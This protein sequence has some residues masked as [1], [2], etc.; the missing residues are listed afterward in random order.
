MVSCPKLHKNS[1][2]YAIISLASGMMNSVFFFYYVN[3]FLNR[4][5]IQESWFQTSQVLFMIWNAIND[6]LFGYWQDNFRGECFKT[7]SSAIKYGALLWAISFLLPWFPWTNDPAN[8][9]IIGIHL[10]VS[11]FMYDA[12][13]T[14][15]LLAQCAVFTEMS[16]RTEDRMRL[17]RYTQVASFVG[18]FSVFVCEYFSSNLKN[19]RTFQGIT[20]VI[21]ILAWL[22][23][24][25][26][27]NNVMTEYDQT[28]PNG[29]KDTKEVITPGTG[30]TGFRAY[31]K[32]TWQIMKNWNFICFVVTNFLTIFC[33]TYLTNFSR[34]ICNYLIPDTDLSSFWR[35]ALYGS[36]MIIPQ[37]C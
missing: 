3:I 34:I 14:S 2:A 21:A 37:V 4:Y 30:G 12:L 11:L 10:T 9:V 23:L 5:K 13:L 6:P 25:Y 32:L 24:R 7:R 28:L 15:V 19:Y 31:L 35:S 8:T 1:F 29:N 16:K 20:I 18:H 27:G 17:V 22:L 26:A 33:S 36:F